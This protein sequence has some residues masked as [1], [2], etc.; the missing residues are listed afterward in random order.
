[1]A[2]LFGSIAIPSADCPVPEG[3]G[4]AVQ[5][6]AAPSKALVLKARLP[7]FRPIQTTFGSILAVAIDDTL[8]VRV[9]TSV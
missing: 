6:E 2:V 4:I 3:S 9:S 8:L 5:V 7:L 1:V